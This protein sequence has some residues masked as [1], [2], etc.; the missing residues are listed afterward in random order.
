MALGLRE[1]RFAAG[2]RAAA[3][4]IITSDHG[5]EF[6]DHGN[7]GHGYAPW[8]EQVHVPLIIRLPGGHLGGLR[9]AEQVRTIDVMPTVL[10]LLDI[11]ND[12]TMRGE[13]LVPFMA[14]SPTAGEARMAFTD[15]GHRGRVSVR[16]S[17]WKIIYD[18]RADAWSA[19]HLQ[20]DP[21]ETR[22]RFP[23]DLAEV[24]SLRAALETWLGELEPAMTSPAPPTP[25]DE[26]LEQLRTLGYLGG[27]S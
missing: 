26:E 10:E 15:R 18:T 7:T 17:E 22:D 8:D 24:Q 4:L 5:E 9:V 3:V 13:S 12:A 21:G 11:P 23:E 2:L 20:E 25:S 14:T 1:V 19:Y 27:D 16:T 6:L